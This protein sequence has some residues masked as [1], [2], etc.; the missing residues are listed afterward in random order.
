MH[1]PTRFFGAPVAGSLL[2]IALAPSI[3]SA[4]QLLGSEIASKT[5]MDINRDNAQWRPIGTHDVCSLNGLTYD[6]NHDVLYGISP[7]TDNI[8]RID[9]KTAHATQIG[10]PGALGFPNANG[11]A[12]DPNNNVLYATDNNTNSLLTVD[13]RTGVGTKL[14]TIGGGFTEIEGL[15]YDGK[16]G[17]LYG[18]TQLQRR[19]VE[20]DVKTGLARAVSDELPQLVWRGLD[21]DAERRVLFASAVKI[22][23]DA[24]LYSFE[25]VSKTLT[26]IGQ[27]RGA[28]AVQ[29]LAYVPE[30]SGALLGLAVMY[31][32]ATRR[33]R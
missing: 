26:F 16:T 29:G 32:S 14:A 30:P 8:Y 22:F 6:P 28:E 23:D 33:R 11:L 31:L 24:P 9:R 12:Y 27:M 25:P 3:V 2:I 21:F 5:L 7:A 17:T 10:A 20:I 4:G 18:L 13:V 15:G 1:Q 19:I